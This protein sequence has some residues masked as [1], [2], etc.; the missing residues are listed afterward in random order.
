LKFNQLIKAKLFYGGN[1]EFPHEMVLS[2]AALDAGATTGGCSNRS[3]LLLSYR[4]NG[5]Y[6]NVYNDGGIYY[7]DLTM[8]RFGTQSSLATSWPSC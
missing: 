5:D 7:Q 3:G 8:N 6:V 4:G 1:A 2:E